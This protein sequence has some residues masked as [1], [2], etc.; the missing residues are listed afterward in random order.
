M[1]AAPRSRR[2]EKRFAPRLALRIVPRSGCGL[3]PRWF[4]GWSISS[5]S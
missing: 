2:F 1:A 5:T 3:K 4:V